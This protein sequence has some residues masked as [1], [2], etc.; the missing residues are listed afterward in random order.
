RTMGY[1][2]PKAF[3]LLFFFL[4]IGQL[5]G[6]TTTGSVSGS[7]SDSSGARIASATVR[8]INVATNEARTAVSSASG[9]YVFPSVPAGN[10]IVEAESSGF[11]T[12]RRAGIRLDVNQNARVDFTLQIGQATQVVQVTSD[13]PL[14]QDL[15]L[16]GRNVYDLTTLMPG[17]V[18]VNTSLTG[19][20]DANNMN[21]NGNR[22]RA[23]NF[24]LDGAANNALFRNGG[25]QAPN[26]DAVFEF[27]LI[28]SNFDAEYGRL[29]GSVM[30]VVTRSGS[31]AFHGTLFDF[32]RN[33]V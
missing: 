29:P 30:N 5:P 26:P 16:N 27:H 12:E 31:N 25:N 4:L 1:A 9:D 6:Q 32:L 21:V 3:S 10:Y 8:L 14:V 15:P 23:N 2:R 13:A 20:N 28:T 33:D 7:V 18:N 19:N 11:R 17:V 24:F 22:V